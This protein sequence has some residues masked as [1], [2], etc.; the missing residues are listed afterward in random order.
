MNQTKV[1]I[2][3]EKWYKTNHTEKEK[4]FDNKNM[5]KVHLQQCYE[6]AQHLTL[7]RF[8]LNFAIIF[9]IS[10]ITEGYM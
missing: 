9:I 5:N 2:V 10:V 1:F 4:P 8:F 6:Q 7:A 3:L